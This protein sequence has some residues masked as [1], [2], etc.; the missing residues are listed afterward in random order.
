MTQGLL[1]GLKTNE[2]KNDT[3]CILSNI[4]VPYKFYYNGIL[5]KL[6]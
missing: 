5:N 3:K 2:G 6:I 4:D 1:K